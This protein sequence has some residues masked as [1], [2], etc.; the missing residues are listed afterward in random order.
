M[1]TLLPD[2]A[3]ARTVGKVEA[4][5]CYSIVNAV[6]RALAKQASRQVRPDEDRGTS[7]QGPHPH[8]PNGIAR[9]S[10]AFRDCSTEGTPAPGQW[11]A[12]IPG[13]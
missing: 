6:V 11:T 4:W 7:Y 1:S 13:Q 8:A 2:R 10:N 5:R 3:D 12:V 9:D